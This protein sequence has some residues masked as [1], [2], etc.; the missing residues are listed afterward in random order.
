MLKSGLSTPPSN[1]PL[2]ISP[3]SPTPILAHAI[4]KTFHFHHQA[5]D[6]STQQT[7]IPTHKPWSP[8]PPG[9]HKI[10][11]DAAVRPNNVYLAAICRNHMGTIT[12]AW[13]KVEV[14]GDSLWAEAKASLFAVSCALDAGLDS[15]IF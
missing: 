6:Y 13:I 11:F 3:P 8:P 9:W 7:T 12:H 14:H 5:W 2:P 4:Q 1:S 10:N 15:I